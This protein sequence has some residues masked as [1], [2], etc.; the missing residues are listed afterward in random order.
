VLKHLAASIGTFGIIL[1]SAI[2]VVAATSN[3]S[4]VPSGGFRYYPGFVRKEAVIETAHDKG[5]LVEFIVNCPVGWGIITLSK[6]ERLYCLPDHNCTKT[7]KATVGR[8]C[9]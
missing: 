9:Q 8:L 5:S 2:S 3:D 6:I 7:L 1:T 4:S